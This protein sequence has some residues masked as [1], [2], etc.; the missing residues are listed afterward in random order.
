VLSP[1]CA[2][3]GGER[4]KCYFYHCVRA[5]AAPVGIGCKLNGITKF[6][7]SGSQCYSAAFG[8]SK[9]PPD[10]SMPCLTMLITSVRNSRASGFIAELM[11]G[12]LSS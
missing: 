1:R 8:M 6:S 2:P 7:D 5:Q 4:G 3:N 12:A 11:G 10:F 9:E